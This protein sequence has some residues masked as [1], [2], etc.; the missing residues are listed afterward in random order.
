MASILATAR[1]QTEPDMTAAVT[2]VSAMALGDRSF[3]PEQMPVAVLLLP[4][5][6][7]T[8]QTAKGTRKCSDGSI[9]KTGHVCGGTTVKHHQALR[10]HGCYILL[11]T[12]I[13]AKLML[14]QELVDSKVQSAFVMGEAGEAALHPVLHSA[15]TGGHASRQKTS[16]HG[17]QSGVAHA[18]IVA[19]AVPD[20]GLD[21]K[22]VR[23]VI[24]YDL[25]CS[26]HGPHAF[27][28]GLRLG[29]MLTQLN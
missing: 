7:P 29:H 22:D 8:V 25:P 10:F 20:R 9:L 13:L 4:T 1:A 3:Q 2:P 17:V 28:W 18:L 21:I 26:L 11:A 24:N 5:P 27:S 6:K 12:T 16:S 15:S 23:H 19:K 14:P